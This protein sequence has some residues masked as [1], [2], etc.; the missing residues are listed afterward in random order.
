[1]EKLE[2]KYVSRCGSGLQSVPTWLSV[3]SLLASSQWRLLLLSFNHCYVQFFA[4][5]WTAACQ[6]PLSM[7]FHRQECLSGLPF[8]APGD[9]PDLGIKPTSLVSAG[10][11]FTTE[12]P[13]KPKHA[14]SI[15]NVPQQTGTFCTILW[16]YIDAS[17][18]PQLV[19]NPPAM[20]ETWVWPLGWGHPLEKG[21][22][23]H[24]SI[25][26]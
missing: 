25:P 19:K 5:L 9:L 18:V 14:Y 22:A 21:K 20:Q 12:P 10:R 16:T 24:S 13:G 8:P 6:A 4:T 11:F 7:G 23:T 1:M 26:A 17:L 15:I 3:K 2:K